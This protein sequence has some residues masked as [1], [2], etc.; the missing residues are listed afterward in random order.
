MYFIF[1]IIIFIKHFIVSE[2][3]LINIY[4]PEFYQLFLFI[5]Y[6]FFKVFKYVSKKFFKFFFHI[7]NELNID[8][9]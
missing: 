4:H 6:S 3:Y 8:D 5:I 2:A 7:Y 1:I 9:V